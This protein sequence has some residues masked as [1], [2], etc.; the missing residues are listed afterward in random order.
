[1]TVNSKRH[2]FPTE[3][4]R[5]YTYFSLLSTLIPN[6]QNNWGASAKPCR[7][8]KLLKE[9]QKFLDGGRN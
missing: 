1:M 4:D 5:L 8:L 9:K 2:C 3:E 6:P 7:W